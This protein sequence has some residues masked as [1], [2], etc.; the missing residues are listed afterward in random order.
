MITPPALKENDKIAIIAPARKISPE[1]IKPAVDLFESWG[2][3]V[4]Y[5]NHL[6]RSFYQFAGTDEERA[7]DL[8]NFMDDPSIKAIVCARGGYGTVRL[9]EYLNFEQFKQHPKWIIGYSDITV[10]HSYI[11]HQLGIN[12]LHATMPLNIRKGSEELQAIQLLKRVLFGGSLEY[13]WNVVPETPLPET[14][15]APIT[16]GNLSVLY[17]V[18]GTLFDIDT[19]GKILFI[20]DLDEYLYHIDRMLMNFKHSHKFSRLKALLVGGMTDM[21]DNKIPYG[22]SAREIIANITKTYHFPVISGFPAGH[23]KNN[24]PIIMGSEVCI[25]QVAEDSMKIQ[26]NA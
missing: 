8:Q 7:T 24:F 1:E 15:T 10:L 17:S 26:F 21:N 13:T 2:L 5:G 14:I 23:F 9:M 20:E 3:E 4:V 6:F 11:T 16:G 25:Q 19:T 22:F 12:T 18:S